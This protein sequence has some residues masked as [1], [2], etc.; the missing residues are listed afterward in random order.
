MDTHVHGAI[1]SLR[2]ERGKQ[3]GKGDGTHKLACEKKIEKS[4][5]FDRAK[6]CAAEECGGN[7][8]VDDEK[9]QKRRASEEIG[10]GYSEI[11][12]V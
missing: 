9:C 4:F 7:P 1:D 12:S 10:I 6:L 5:V 11:L 3:G 8:N 2:E